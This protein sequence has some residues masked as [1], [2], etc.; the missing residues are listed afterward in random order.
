MDAPD[1]EPADELAT[2]DLHPAW[3]KSF[4]DTWGREWIDTVATTSE[5]DLRGHM[6]ALTYHQYAIALRNYI[7]KDETTWHEKNWADVAAA[8]ADTQQPYS[9]NW[10][11]FG[12]WAT[13]TINRDIRSDVVPVRSSRLLPFGLRG[14]LTPTVLAVKN[15]DRQRISELLT[16]YQRLVFISTTLAFLDL[17]NDLRDNYDKCVAATARLRDTPARSKPPLEPNRHLTPITRAFK[18]YQGAALTHRKVAKRPAKEK[19]YLTT[20]RERRVL[21]AT[22]ILTAVEQ[23]VVQP[24]VEKVMEF[25]PRWA[26]DRVAFRTARLAASLT[27]IPRQIAGLRVPAA[28]SGAED[29]ATEVWARV[30][31]D[32]ILVLAMP[33]EVLR[34]GRDIPPVRDDQPMF[35]NELRHLASEIPGTP[36]RGWTKP[37][38]FDGP[39]DTDANQTLRDLVASFDRSRHH[40]EGSAADDWRQYLDRMNWAV[41]LLRS[42]QQEKS[43]FWPPYVEE[44]M[45]RIKDCRRP[46]RSADPCQ[47]EVMAPL[48][49][50]HYDVEAVK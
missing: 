32:Q 15:A 26:T 34:L 39:T 44:D 17:L 14:A 12:T 49:A 30:V 21:L 46:V 37:P 20:L 43:L 28:F 42:R 2:D 35:P 16:W 38:D 33:A 18:E 31:T 36:P 6:I 5:R 24:G 23:D 45:K 25:V 4:C 22:L 1:L 41:T 47:Y 7:Y 19:E 27:G 48:E 9:A 8:W 13:A 3:R 29:T 10:F 50:Y 11:N 40:G